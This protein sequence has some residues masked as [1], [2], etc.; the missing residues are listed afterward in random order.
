VAYTDPRDGKEK[1]AELRLISMCPSRYDY[2]GATSLRAAVNKREQQLSW[3]Q[4]YLNR[5]RSKDT[6]RLHTPDGEVG[7]LERG[8]TS[9]EH[10][11][12]VTSAHGPEREG[13]WSRNIRTGTALA[14]PGPHSMKGTTHGRTQ[15][16]RPPSGVADVVEL[17]DGQCLSRG[18]NFD[19]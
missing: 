5:L 16:L 18:L 15:S 10:A 14:G 3:Y 9:A 8:F 2:Q 6:E 19:W 4:E 17:R 1:I 11:R 12:E 7:P 13:E